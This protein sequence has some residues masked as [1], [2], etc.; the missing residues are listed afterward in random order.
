MRSKS[1]FL[2]ALI[3]AAA[4]PIAG[5][6]QEPA[7]TSRAIRVFLDC[8]ECD[9]DHL[10]REIRFVDYVRQPADAELHVLV[11]SQQTGAGGDRFTFFFIGQG[12]FAGRQDTLATTV[13]P[14]ATDAEERDALTTTLAVG[15]VPYAARTELAAGLRIGF[16]VVGDDE[17]GER[18]TTPANDPWNLWVFRAGLSTTLQ[19]ESTQREINFDGSLSA[20]RTTDILKMDFRINGDYTSEFI[21]A[22]DEDEEDLTFVRRNYSGNALVVRSLGDHLSV[23]AYFAAESSSRLNQDLTFELSPAIEYNLYPYDESSRRQILFTYRVGPY[24][25]DYEEITL[26]GKTRETLGQHALEISAA[27]QQPWG[28]VSGSLE[29]SNFLH[30]FGLHRVE[31]FAGMDVRLFRG[32]SLE[33]DGNIARIK[34][35]IYLRAAGLTEEEILLGLRERGTDYEYE[36]DI[37]FSYS[38]GSVFNNVVNPRLRLNNNRFNF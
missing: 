19:G 28:E 20:S 23:G 15:L 14:D 16:G 9:F 29:G 6:A 37:G 18:Q 7:A 34:D 10:R 1:I 21:K 8:R 32:F 25:A 30:D 38:F 4:T 22:E 33:L 12:R 17:P 5:A 11:T 3:A 31:L 24:Y 35:Q 13:A 2:L 27:I 36:I 26:F